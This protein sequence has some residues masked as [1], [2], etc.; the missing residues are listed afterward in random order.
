MLGP[1]QVRGKP[2]GGGYAVA[3][4]LGLVLSTLAVAAGVSMLAL[5]ASPKGA[6]A[7]IA[8]PTS[9]PTNTPITC[10]TVVLDGVGSFNGVLPTCTPIQIVRSATPTLTATVPA[11]NTPAPPP[12]TA[13]PTNSPVP[14][15]TSPAG[16]AGAAIVAPNTGG[17]P[18][19]AGN[20][21]TLLLLG[22]VLFVL[23]AGSLTMAVR[24]YR[25][26]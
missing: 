18:T 1:N 8:G 5:G 13:V 12:A 14:T 4:I 6:G 15:A 21:R 19:A 16:G 26:R 7:T 23:G 22:T 2:A 20:N 25:A 3:R 9:T 11:T 17:G 10:T 24:G